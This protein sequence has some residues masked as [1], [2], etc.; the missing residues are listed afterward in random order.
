[1]GF[2]DESA[3]Q[4]AQIDRSTFYR[5]V[6]T[7]VGFATEMAGAKNFARL[8]CSS[9]LIEAAKSGNVQVCEWWLERRFREDF[10]KTTRESAD[11]EKER[12]ADAFARIRDR[13]IVP[14]ATGDRENG[15]VQ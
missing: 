8:L 2:S 3:C 5:H 11:A 10:G 1:M 9:V 4:Y 12:S 15:A 6:Q 13:Y 14:S 7:D